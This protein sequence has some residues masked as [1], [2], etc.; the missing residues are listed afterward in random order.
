MPNFFVTVELDIEARDE[1][2]AL[3]IAHKKYGYYRVLSA[4]SGEFGWNNA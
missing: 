2:E 1:R 3:D 4:K